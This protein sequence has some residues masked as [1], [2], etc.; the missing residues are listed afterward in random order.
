MPERE[1]QWLRATRTMADDGEWLASQPEAAPSPASQTLVSEIMTKTVH[2]LRPETSLE[3][4]SALFLAHGISGAPVVN[5]EGRPIGIV[6]KTDLVRSQYED[7]DSATW[8]SARDERV[9]PGLHV[10]ATSGKSAADVMMPVVFVLR[11]GSTVAMASA[12]L[13]AED[14]HRAPVV[15]RHGKVVGIVSAL[16]I[17]RWLATHE[18]YVIQARSRRRDDP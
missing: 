14:I 9:E 1:P 5:D 15:S 17:V 2:T 6:T 12:L 13:A 3:A 18:R 11:S 16:D 10:E 4:I 7:P 8:P